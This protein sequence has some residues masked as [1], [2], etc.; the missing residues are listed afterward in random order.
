M[1]DCNGITNIEVV[2]GV[3]SLRMIE[4]ELLTLGR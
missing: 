4:M 2:T 1:N 3:I